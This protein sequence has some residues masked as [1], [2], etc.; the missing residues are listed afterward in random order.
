MTKL[1]IRGWLK[2]RIVSA[3]LHDIIPIKLACW[4]IKR[5]GLSHE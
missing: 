3:A 4:L 2:S 1:S 5:G